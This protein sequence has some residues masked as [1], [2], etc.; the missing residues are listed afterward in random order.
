MMSYI[1]AH[2]LTAANQA[3]HLYSA[4]GSSSCSAFA[5]VI[6]TLSGSQ[7]RRFLLS[8]PHQIRRMTVFT[9]I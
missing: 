3:A 1:W 8:L 4:Q 7:M 2:E 5:T 6:L 9:Y